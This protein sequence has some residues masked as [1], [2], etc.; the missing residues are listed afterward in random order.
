MWADASAGAGAGGRRQ[1]ARG[2]GDLGAGDEPG[3]LR[4]KNDREH[5][6]L[7]ALEGVA[8]LARG[9]VGLAGVGQVPELER[10]VQRPRRQQ[11]GVRRER[12]RV[13]RVVVPVKLLQQ[14]PGLEL[15]QPAPPRPIPHPSALARTPAP[16]LILLTPSRLG[17]HTTCFAHA[18]GPTTRLQRQGEGRG[19][20]SR[21]G[22]RT[23][24]R[25]RGSRRRCSDCPG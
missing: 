11:L 8:A 12:H 2:R 25:G 9:A 16:R 18:L 6:V 1:A 21:D 17:P 24:R 7:V 5:E 14:L 4:G 15:P 19:E 13:D 22:G 10:L 23:G 3:A 20:R